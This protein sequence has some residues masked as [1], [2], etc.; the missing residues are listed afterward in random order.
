MLGYVV[1]YLAMTM[2]EEDAENLQVILEQAS[3][4]SIFAA[5]LALRLNYSGLCKLIESKVLLLPDFQIIA[6]IVW[7]F[8]VCDNLL[9]L[10]LLLLS[11]LYA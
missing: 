2:S 5:V 3:S 1:S 11:F 7:H 10:L 9:L 4:L 6:Y 8:V